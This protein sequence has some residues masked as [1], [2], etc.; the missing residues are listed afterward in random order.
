VIEGC[1]SRVS[2]SLLF[3]PIKGEKV[4]SGLT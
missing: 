1:I 4:K 3:S 2:P